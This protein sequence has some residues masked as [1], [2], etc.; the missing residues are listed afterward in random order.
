VRQVLD[1]R[2]DP[3][4]EVEVAEQVDGARLAFG[5]RLAIEVRDEVEQLA[6]GQFFVEVRTIT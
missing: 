3:V 2:V 4:A 5:P 1:A 6:A